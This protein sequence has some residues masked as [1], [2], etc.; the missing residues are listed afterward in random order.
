MLEN[1]PTNIDARDNYLKSHETKMV[2]KFLE[3]I[4]SQSSELLTPD[5]RGD[6]S[7]MKFLTSLVYSWNTFNTL[8]SSYENTGKYMRKSALKST[9]EEIDVGVQIS[10][11]TSRKLPISNVYQG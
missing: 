8:R 9:L 6:D 7:F 1:A 2:E 5:V 10:N 4:C 3:E 11:M